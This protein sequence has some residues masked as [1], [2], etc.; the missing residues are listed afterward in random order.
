LQQDNK[1]SNF[2]TEVC[3][4][5]RWKKTHKVIFNEIQNHLMEQ[6]DEYIDSGYTEE[7]A[8]EK[9]INDFGD[10]AYI[11]TELDRIHRPKNQ[12]ICFTI[13]GILSFIGIFL[14]VVIIVSDNVFTT[15]VPQMLSYV[16]GLVVLIGA[17]FIDFTILSRFSVHLYT[18]V[19]LLSIVLNIFPISGSFRYYVALLYPFAISCSLYCLRKKG[20]WGI[21]VNTILSLVLLIFS[22]FTE[23]M[24][25]VFLCLFESLIII[26]V[27]I[28][29]KWFKVKR[30]FGLLICVCPLILTLILLYVIPSTKE[31]IVSVL[32]CIQTGERS[33]AGYIPNLLRE[34]TNNARLIGRG[35]ALPTSFPDIFHTDYILAFVLHNYGWLAFG[36]VVVLFYIFIIICF[37]AATKQK[38]VLGELLAWTI[39]GIFTIQIILYVL[40]NLGIL[41]LSLSVLPFVSYGSVSNLINFAM[42]G[43]LL[44]IFR[45]EEIMEDKITKPLITR[46]KI[47]Y[48]ILKLSFEG[49][50][51][52]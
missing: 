16:L 47:N 31:G 44:S 39:I 20:H 38:S 35:E 23:N 4:Q 52:Q 27:S 6:R 49:T 22:F 24:L 14:Q 25:G 37:K 12:F 33:G 11:G 46:Q 42:L 8:T 48:I 19:F 45:N 51:E 5:I 2:C 28:L 26:P 18:L 15:L 7:Q 10:A 1:I 50:D 17:Y 36:F 9:A 13:L 30:S 21:I 29:K 32:S 3:N 41:N 40:S 34:I 43:V